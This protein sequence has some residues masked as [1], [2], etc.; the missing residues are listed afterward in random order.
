MEK[1]DRICFAILKVL[2][3]LLFSCILLIAVVMAF[4]AIFDLTYCAKDTHATAIKE[5]H[6]NL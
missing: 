4:G 5:N 1:M 3:T 2:C 6:N